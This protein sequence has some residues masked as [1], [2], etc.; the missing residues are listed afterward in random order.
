MANPQEAEPVKLF[1]AVLWAQEEGLQSAM[2]RLV[3]Y[4]GEVDFT[5]ADHPFDSTHYY[6][7]EM[8]QNL[9]RRLI[10]FLQLFPPEQLGPAKHI[11]ND[12]EEKLAGDGGRIVNLD[13]GYLDENKIVLASFKG[14]GQKIYLGNGAWADLV[15]RYRSGR[16]SPFEWTF[17]DF[18]DGRYDQDLQTI[19]SIYRNQIKGHR[20]Q[21]TSRTSET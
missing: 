6:E 13:I 11:S 21:V 20:S 7:P 1:V 2:E 5:G 18:R 3:E 17:P 9:Q 19:R 12:I 16:Y 15:A 8:G 4:W 14:A 10:T